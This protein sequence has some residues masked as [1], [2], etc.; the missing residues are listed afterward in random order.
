M[1]EAEPFACGREGG[2]G[3]RAG[4]DAAC[5]E[6]DGCFVGRREGDARC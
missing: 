6:V 2:A 1:R 5:I 3:T 4:K